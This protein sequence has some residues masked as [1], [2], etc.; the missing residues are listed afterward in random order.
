MATQL[1]ASPELNAALSELEKTWTSQWLEELKKLVR[2]PSVSFEGFDPKEVEKSAK[3]TA[4]LLKKAGLEN[5][6]VIPFPGAHPYVYADYCHSPGALTVLYYAHHDVQ[7]PGRVEAW[8]TKPY[9]PIEKQ[10]P[11]GMRLYGR[12]AA[13]DKAGIVVIA[14]CL[15]ATLKT[16]KSLPI[17]VKVIIEG[18]EESGS[19]NLEAFLIQ[20]KQKLNADI[21]VLTDTTNFDVG[22]PSLTTA[23]RGMVGFE[24]EIRALRNTLHSGMWG[25]PI[26]DPVM[27]MNKVFAS[28]TDKHGRICIPGIQSM[29]RPMDSAEEIRLRK[30]HC[31][32][33]KFKEQAGMLPSATLLKEG[34]SLPA[35]TWRF[36]SLTINAFQ[37]S[38]RAQASNIINDASWGRISLRLTPEMDAQKVA[39]LVESYIRENTPWGLEV[40]L[41]EIACSPGWS[42]D[43]KHLDSFGQKVFELAEDALQEGYSHPVI[44]IGCGGS[45][46]FVKPF[47]NALGGAPAL[48]VGVEDPYT[49]AHGENE[50]VCIEDLKKAAISQIRLLWKLKGLDPKVA[51]QKGAT[52]KGTTKNNHV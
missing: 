11:G 33:D 17:N 23:L 48:L 16:L 44:Q 30:I 39:T 37:A 22:Y 40:N 41:K 42:T 13:D 47:A 26:P 6:E 52:Q 50:S 3:A 5:V 15:G 24:V 7:P 32:D 2:I 34:P 46:P 35:Q 49:N 14:S 8:K 31:E 20:Y 36:P 29:V 4:E 25:G 18:E 28:M 27:A 12:G 43:P 21:M 1:T 45:I 51:T 19:H 38:S 10:G 9:E